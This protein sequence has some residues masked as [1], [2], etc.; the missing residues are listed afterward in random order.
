MNICG[1]I[2]E[3][4]PFHN[5]HDY[6]IKE[7]QEVTNA[8]CMIAVMSGSFL[9]RGEPAIIDKFHRAKAA[10]NSGI[11]IVVELPFVYAVESSDL[12]AKGSV[13][14]LHELGVN[15]ICFGSESGDIQKFIQGYSVFIENKDMFQ[16]IL[17]TALKSGKSFPD[18][19]KIAYE[20]IG[21]TEDG[22]DLSKPNNILGF[23]YVKTILENKLPIQPSTIRRKNN[24]YHDTEITGSITSATSIRKQIFDHQIHIS[25]LKH[26]MPTATIDQLTVYN[27]QAKTLHYWEKY[28]PFLHYRVTTMSYEE[29]RLI[30][31]VEEGIEY[32]IKK[33]AKDVHSF[34]EWVERI[35]TKRYTWTRIQR[36]FVHILTNTKKTEINLLSTPQS[37]PYVRLLGMTKKGQHYLNKI[38]KEMNVPIYQK[39]SRDLHPMLQLEERATN[40]YY[41]I[42]PSENRYSLMQQEFKGPVRIP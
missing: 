13:M 27:N 40:T 41:S 42:L 20:A 2:V 1:L 28:Y 9:Q 18:A 32:R 5:G 25:A 8:D 17:K 24:E 15:N 6:H 29:L 26:T 12:F 19:S 4:N 22:M 38:K 7:A 23:S 30:H 33:A 3:Y 11:D 21:L 36:I 34:N 16:S 31:G 35:K 39:L 37:V 14:T 10:L